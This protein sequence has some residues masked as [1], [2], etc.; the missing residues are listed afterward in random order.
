M[1]T[2]L[3]TTHREVRL[4]AVPHGLPRP[5]DFAVVEAP[6]PL[7]GPGEVLVR[8]RL[9]HVAG[10]LRMLIA[11]ATEG[12]P[13]PVLRPG[14]T[15]V[16]A[17][18]GEVVTAPGGTGLQ[19]G[20][21]V[22][23]WSGWRE[24]AVVPA[25]ECTPLDADLPDPVASLSMGWTA[26][27]ALTRGVELRPGDT[28]FVSSGA[29]AIGSMAGRIAR[30]LGAGRVIGSTGSPAKAE[31]LVAELGYD[32]AV[33]RSAQAPLAEQ[34][35][36]AAPDGIDVLLDSVGGDQLQA[37]VRVARP[38][39]R[40]VLVG[41]LSGQLDP[42]RPGTGSPVELDS[43]QLILKRITLRGFSAD[44]VATTARAE[45]TARLAGW[46]RSGEI[47]VPHVRIDGIERAPQAACEVVRG[48]HLGL[49]V[50]EL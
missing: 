44:D 3:P 7:P 14:D 37:A 2:A 38:G 11:G 45:W 41:A 9:F 42:A 40:Y 20:D 39:A 43:F 27:A 19:S 34:L 8:N 15:L 31:R 50:V 30:L 23:H 16:G 26:Y 17:A 33:V 6:L 10:T 35:A 22:T 47:A 46:L 5:E 48:G 49:V 32:A 1:P 29:G 21:L 4:A 13:F 18:V 24:Y 28:V 36:L 25:A 12:T